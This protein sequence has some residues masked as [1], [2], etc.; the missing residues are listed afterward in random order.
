MNVSKK[1]LKQELGQENYMA[2]AVVIR[3]NI[4]EPKREIRM[5]FDGIYEILRKKEGKELRQVEKRLEDT[6]TTVF[7]INKNYFGAA[8]LYLAALLVLSLYT[9]PQVALP[10]ILSATVIF[11]VKTYEFVVN[12]FCYVDAGMILIFRTVLQQVLKEQKQKEQNETAF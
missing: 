9:V 10:A 12:K 4:H 1:M 5:I 8:V 3:K 6:V 7:H 2:Y 11:S